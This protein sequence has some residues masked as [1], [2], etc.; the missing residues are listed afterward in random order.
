MAV[1]GV[2]A[3]SRAVLALRYSVDLLTF[4]LDGLRFAFPADRVVQVVQ[5]V[6]ISPL[7][8]APAVVEGVVNVRGTVMPVLDLRG[9]LG[10]PP[11]PVEPGQH[12][13]ILAAGAR[14]A[15][16]RVDAVDEFLSIPESDITPS[17]RLADAGIGAVRSPYVSG[18]AETVNGTTIIYD[19]AT[20]LSLSESS[21][22]D[23]AL[24]PTG[25]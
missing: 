9:R 8:G 10:L 15:A 3:H 5:M 7:P 23:Q 4:D 12:L 1:S 19:L 6:A 18:V 20:F 17:E 2:R 24:A 13:V 16:V 14:S 25:G 11:R 21:S 22:I